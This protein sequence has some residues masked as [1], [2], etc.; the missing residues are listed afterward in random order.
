MCTP[1]YKKAHSTLIEIHFSLFFLKKIKLLKFLIILFVFFFN[2]FE[3]Y[4]EQL[5]IKTSGVW[6]FFINIIYIFFKNLTYVIGWINKID[7][8]IKVLTIIIF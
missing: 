4:V 5:A 1:K 6:F 7:K 2:R 8:L 3:V